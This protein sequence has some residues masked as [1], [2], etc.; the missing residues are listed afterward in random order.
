MSSTA[1][2]TRLAYV[3]KPVHD[4]TELEPELIPMPTRSGESGRDSDSWFT[5]EKYIESARTVLG[6]IG[7]DPFSSDYA[8]RTV[9]AQRHFTAEDDAFSQDWNPGKG[10]RKTCFMNPPYSNPLMRDAVER[11]VGEF[12][13]GSFTTGI[14]LCNAGTDTRWWK[15]L[16]SRCRML[17]LTDHRISF[18][19]DDGKRKSGNTKGQAFFFFEARKADGTL[20]RGH[21]A[22]GPVF[23]REF[24]KHG[25]VWQP[26]Q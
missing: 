18:V 10:N 2:K 17:C 9:R 6:V 20:P 13:K 7:L 25:Q 12:E 4:K 16:A 3:G 11:F 15:L 24:Q 19:T 1:D 23:R 22:R 21:K 8:N 14:V 26:H 5:P